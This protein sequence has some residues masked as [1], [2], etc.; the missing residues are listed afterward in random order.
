MARRLGRGL[1]HGSELRFD[2]K[3]NPHSQYHP[4]LSSTRCLTTPQPCTWAL[5]KAACP[6][7]GPAL[8][9]R[10]CP[11]PP[12]CQLLPGE[13]LLGLKLEAQMGLGGWVTR[14]V[15]TLYCDALSE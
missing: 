2:P 3:R 6:Q 12:G 8:T 7:P 15:L 5:E 13:N 4:V 10:T 11:P 1:E 14:P 9:T